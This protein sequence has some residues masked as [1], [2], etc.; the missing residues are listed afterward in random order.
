MLII[1]SKSIMSNNM[2][3][4]IKKTTGK[5]AVFSILS[6]LIA[7]GITSNTDAFAMHDTWQ[8]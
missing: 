3:N 6:V 5:L 7:V 1:L 8:S 2:N 4:K